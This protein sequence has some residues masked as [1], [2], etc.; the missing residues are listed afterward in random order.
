[1]PTPTGRRRPRV[2]IWFVVCAPVNP[3][4]VDQAS[5]TTAVPPCA[6][7]ESTL[8]SVIATTAE[9][10]SLGD[11]LRNVLAAAATL[12]GESSVGIVHLEYGCDRVAHWSARAEARRVECDPDASKVL[13]RAL[14][15]ARKHGAGA[16]TAAHL[17]LALDAWAR[18]HGLAPEMM[19]R[20]RARI[21]A[22]EGGPEA[23]VNLRNRQSP[24]GVGDL[25]P[26]TDPPV[27][28]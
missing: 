23:A 13:R 12:A 2:P 17:R 19:A 22:D 14:E 4:R 11:D 7:K 3:T 9:G 15:T 6:G 26:F 24:K 8:D 1:M 5:A 28:A 18:R 16:A 27:A 21:V 20:V 10:Q 25:P